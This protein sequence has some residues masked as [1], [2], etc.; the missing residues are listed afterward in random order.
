MS[1]WFRLYDDAINDPKVL[2]MPDALKWHWVAI[3]C[4]ASKNK[5]VLP[6]IH[7]IALGLRI[8][9]KK[10]TAI[11]D[12]L[13]ARELLDNIDGMFLPHNWSGRQ[14]QSDSS[15]ERVKRHRAKRAATGLISQWTAPKALRQQVYERDGFA[16]VYCGSTEQLSLDHRTPEIRGGSHEAANLATACLACNGAKRDMTEQ[17]FKERNAAVTL[18]ETLLKRPQSTEQSTDKKDAPKQAPLFPVMPRETTDESEY[19]T[20]GK[21]VLGADA[22]GLLVRLLNSKKKNV[23]LARAAIEQASTKGDPREY[24]GR[25]IAGPAAANERH[26]IND[27]LAG[28]Q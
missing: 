3:L 8:S 16:C 9:L 26:G 23:A 2:R 20:R 18:H 5:G 12:D 14:Y 19:F 28:I 25:I 24:I 17:E 4:V 6:P 13:V 21:K 15:A 22:G 27:P 7:D 1:R 10:A 11:V